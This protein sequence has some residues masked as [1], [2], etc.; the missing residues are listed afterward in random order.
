MLSRD[1]YPVARRTANALGISTV[2][3]GIA[4]NRK[5]ATVRGVHAMGVRVAMVGDS[6]VLGALRVADV[7]ILMTSS[8][9]IDPSAADVADV[10]MQRE[11]V[12]A[13][14]ELVNLVRHIRNTTDWNVWLSWTYN[15][16]GAALAVAGVLNPLL[17]TVFMLLSST[18]IETRSARILH[19]NYARGTLRQTH[20]WQGW[21]ERRREIRELRK[22]ESQRAEAISLARAEAADEEYEQSQR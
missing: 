6:D 4:P 19:R 20:S 15:A 10:V 18:L 13:L 1:I 22:Q 17:A 11:D 5:E 16:V 2:L 9:R 7:G 14:P 12:S 3:A 21:V 8:N